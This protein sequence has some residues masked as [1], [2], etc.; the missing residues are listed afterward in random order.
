MVRGPGWLQNLDEVNEKN[1]SPA[2]RVALGF[3]NFPYQLM[4][5]K[6]EN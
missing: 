6:N 4:L 1:W 3:G 5:S 2:L